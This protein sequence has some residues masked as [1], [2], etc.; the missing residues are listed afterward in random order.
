MGN[1]INAPQLKNNVL[2]NTEIITDDLISFY[3]SV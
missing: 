3:Q 1:G 2:M